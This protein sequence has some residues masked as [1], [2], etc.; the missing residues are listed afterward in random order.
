VA[1]NTNRLALIALLLVVV[2]YGFSASPSTTKYFSVTTYVDGPAAPGYTDMTTLVS[3]GVFTP[4]SFTV[5]C[6]TAPNT[7]TQYAVSCIAYLGNCLTDATV[8]MQSG[9]HEIT[10]TGLTDSAESSGFT[11][12][13][14]TGESGCTGN[15]SGC[16]FNAMFAN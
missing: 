16:A 9:V 11:I 8:T 3:P 5:T 15:A 1:N 7:C 13:L 10:V 14:Q 4:V 12:K 2:G 6:Q